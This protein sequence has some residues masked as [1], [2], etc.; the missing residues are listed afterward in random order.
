MA[1]TTPAEREYLKTEILKCVEGCYAA[2]RNARANGDTSAREPNITTGFL[3]GWFDENVGWG[4]MLSPTKDC[5]DSDDS[6][7]RWLKRQHRAA[8][9]QAAESLRAQ[10]KLSSSL[11]CGANGREARC[12][13]PA[14]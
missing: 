2:F 12:Y 8:V 9:W 1:K 11:G 3:Y 14:A 4:P 5:K 7:V 10:G 6:F 13:E